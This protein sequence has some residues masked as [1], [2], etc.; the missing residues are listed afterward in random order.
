MNEML[1]T[2]KLNDWTLYEIYTKMSYLSSTVCSGNCRRHKYES[3]NDL[4]KFAH[5]LPQ[6]ACLS[7]QGNF[8]RISPLLEDRIFGCVLLE[9]IIMNTKD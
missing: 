8:N 4:I 3:K 6:I 5:F 7:Y 1:T 9:N 2:S